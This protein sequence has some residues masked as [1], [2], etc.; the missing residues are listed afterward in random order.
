MALG[1]EGF[2]VWFLRVFLTGAEGGVAVKNTSITRGS[3]GR[4]DRN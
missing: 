3:C 1:V 4:A 2:P